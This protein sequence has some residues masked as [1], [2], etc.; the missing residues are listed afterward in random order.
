MARNR[1][2]TLLWRSAVFLVPADPNDPPYTALKSCTYTTTYGAEH[3]A[4]TTYPPY[5]RDW[6]CFRDLFLDSTR[7]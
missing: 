3:G 2:F 6:D 1:N 5:I 7:P 4:R